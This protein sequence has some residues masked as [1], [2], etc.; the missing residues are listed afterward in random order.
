MVIAIN[1]LWLLCFAGNQ[2]DLFFLFSLFVIYSNGQLGLGHIN[3]K[4]KSSF[5]CHKQNYRRN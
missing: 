5:F 4:L 2:S 1:L 3:G